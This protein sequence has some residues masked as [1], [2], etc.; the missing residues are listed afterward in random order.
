[1]QTFELNIQIP[2]SQ[3]NAPRVWSWRISDHSW[4]KSLASEATSRNRCRAAQNLGLGLSAGISWSITGVG[5]RQ[6]VARQPWYNQYDS[7]YGIQIVGFEVDFVEVG[8]T[9]WN[10]RKITTQKADDR[11]RK[12]DRKRPY[13]PGT[14]G[15]SSASSWRKSRSRCSLD[16]LRL[17]IVPG[18][19]RTHIP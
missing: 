9:P 2:F 1:M 3:S 17:R 19:H 4:P 15:R 6:L 5:D 16:F 13:V 7:H 11:V 8:E 14:N 12:R 10:V 18:R